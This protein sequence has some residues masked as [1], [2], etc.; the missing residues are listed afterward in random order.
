MTETTD[1]L[2][3]ESRLKNYFT[4]VFKCKPLQASI[5]DQSDLDFLKNIISDEQKQFLYTD[6]TAAEIHHA[7]NKL[8]ETSSTGMDGMTGKITKL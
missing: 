7:T 3:I 6:Y 1:P 5:Y 2:E 4:E 8:R